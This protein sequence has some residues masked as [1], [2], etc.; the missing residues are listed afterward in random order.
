LNVTRMRGDGGI[1]NA[2]EPFL[3]DP[4]QLEAVVI[5]RPYFL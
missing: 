2:Q 3:R 4:G 1:A 5:L